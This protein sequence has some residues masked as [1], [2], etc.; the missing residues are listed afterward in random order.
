VAILGFRF[1][2]ESEARQSAI[3]N[4]RIWNLFGI[5]NFGIWNFPLAAGP[6]FSSY[7]ISNP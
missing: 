6:R 5:W 3:W 7:K 1:G 2:F 4:F